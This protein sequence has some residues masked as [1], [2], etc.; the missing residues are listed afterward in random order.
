MADS[1]KPRTF[2]LYGVE[3]PLVAP[4][5]FDFGELVDCENLLGA[6]FDSDDMDTR[7]LASII[8]VSVRR[9]DQSFTI[10]TLRKLGRAERDE[11][12][13]SIMEWAR[14]DDAAD[15]R[16][17]EAPKSDDS[18]TAQSSDAEQGSSPENGSGEQHDSGHLSSPQSSRSDRPTLIA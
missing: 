12:D 14:E 2:K 8:Y 6:R 13:A 18:P 10:A 1:A 7:R 15:P 16:K 9:V 5:D 17:G 3:Y 4:P 11:I